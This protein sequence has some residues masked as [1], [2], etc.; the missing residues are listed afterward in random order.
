MIFWLCYEGA[1]KPKPW[2][3]RLGKAWQYADRVSLHVPSWTVYKPAAPQPKAYLTG[4]CDTAEL[5]NG[6][7]V[8]Q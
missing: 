6:T 7:M 8:I 3:V 4:K 5:K 1:S 2:S